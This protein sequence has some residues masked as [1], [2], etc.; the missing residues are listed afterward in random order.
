MLTPNLTP[1]AL[2]LPSTS[3]V[4]R[5]I[6]RNKLAGHFHDTYDQALTNMYA[7]LLEG[8]AV[9]D[10]SVAGLG[11]CPYAKGTSRNVAT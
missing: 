10:S 2:A 8:I 4:G 7:I 9:F 6:P 11:G 1:S 3:V 5:D